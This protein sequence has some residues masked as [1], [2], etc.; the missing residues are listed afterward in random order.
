MRDDDFLDRLQ[1]T[2]D[3]LEV[4]ESEGSSADDS[5]SSASRG[6]ELDDRD[7]RQQDEY[8][9]EADS[10]DAPIDLPEDAD[11]RG[12]DSEASRKPSSKQR[13]GDLK[14]KSQQRQ[15]PV[16]SSQERQV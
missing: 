16:P 2:L 6:T 9:S 5:E 14:Q 15:D 8:S 3:G 10:A 13:K 7:G 1:D 4:S 12:R 11:P